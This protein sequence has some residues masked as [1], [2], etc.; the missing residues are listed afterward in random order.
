M[1]RLVRYAAVNI[2]ADIVVGAGAA[3]SCLLYGRGACI[4]L[5]RGVALAYGRTTTSTT[6][7]PPTTAPS[8]EHSATAARLSTDVPSPFGRRCWRRMYP[9]FEVSVVELLRCGPF[10]RHLQVSVS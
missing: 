8:K 2:D 5:G 3:P 9:S 10:R 7:L 6:D 4:T 1:V